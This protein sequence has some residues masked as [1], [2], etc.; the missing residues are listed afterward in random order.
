ME[1]WVNSVDRNY[2]TTSLILAL[3]YDMNVT[4]DADDTADTIDTAD[5]TDNT[6]T[7][8]WHCCDY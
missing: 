7:T 8:D 5:T 2:N 1:L 6:D 3:I 4:T